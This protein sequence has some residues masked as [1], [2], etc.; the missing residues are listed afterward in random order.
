MG[1]KSHDIKVEAA[2]K[3]NHEPH[4]TKT[5]RMSKKLAQVN[6]E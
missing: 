4:K 6:R 1:L 3:E 5:S 2:A